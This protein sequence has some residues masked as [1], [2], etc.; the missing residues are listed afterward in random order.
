LSFSSGYFSVGAAIAAVM[1]KA[2]TDGLAWRDWLFL[3]LQWP[4]LL[5]EA[6]DI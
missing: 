4:C 2:F 1:H 5:V 6:K 3:I